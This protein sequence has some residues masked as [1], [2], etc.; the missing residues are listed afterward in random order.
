LKAGTPPAAPAEPSATAKLFTKQTAGQ[1][2]APG[3]TKDNLLLGDPKA[4]AAVTVETCLQACADDATCKS[5]II[6]KDSKNGVLVGT[7]IT[8]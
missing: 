2:L 5:A 6:L 3:S 8:C 4:N 7:G 1:C